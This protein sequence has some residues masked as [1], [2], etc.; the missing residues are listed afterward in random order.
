MKQPFNT[1][2]FKKLF[3]YFLL[4][5][6]V[7]IAYKLILE[8]DILF[9]AI[10]W[11]LGTIAPF[12]YGF[13]L[14]F[15]L[16]IPCE[17]I[18]KLLGKSKIS[19]IVKRK[20]ALSI[21]ITYLLLLVSVYLALNLVIPSIYNSIHMFVSN[22]KTYYDSAHDF[23]D[24]INEFNIFNINISM[25]G[26]LTAIRDFA[27]EKLPS[28]VNALFDASSAVFNA[29]LAFI[30]SLYILIEKDRF[31]KYLCRLL[32]VFLS[33]EIFGTVLKYTRD[34]SNNVKQYI[35]TQTVDG[36]IIGTLV[37]IELTIIRSP[38]ALILGILIG[39]MNYIPYFGSI[40]GT[41]VTVII[42]ALT[43]GLTTGAITAVVLLI[44]QQIDGNF[45]Q[46]KLM[47]GSFSLSP[48]LVI[49]SIT[50][51]GAL[52]GVLGMLLAIPIIAVLKDILNEIVEYYEKKKLTVPDNENE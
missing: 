28:S 34:L 48:L 17:G 45:I 30:S 22:F 18:R 3:S 13:L 27:I 19:F 52:S 50:V 51:G 42:V 20:K 9:N 39:V 21:V 15:V 32:N 33:K 47:G 6:V 35:Y 26:I 38:Y 7:I 44:T 46:P 49:I 40:F 25:D 24:Y 1:K 23:I 14:A 36:V 8:I 5:V 41:I 31:K 16:N 12:F 11:L 37:A 10:G 4:A 29:L 43:Q 2:Q